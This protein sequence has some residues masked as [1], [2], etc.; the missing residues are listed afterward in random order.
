MK[1]DLV[2]GD[3]ETA[4]YPQI[5]KINQAFVHWL[6]PLDEK[7]L[8]ALLG[9]ATYARQIDAAAGVLIGYGHDVDY[10]HKNLHWLRARFEAFLY[11]DRI[12]IDGAAQGKGYGRVLY[13]DFE[14]EARKRGYPRLV[15]EVNVVPNNPGSHAFHIAQGFS[16][17]EDVYYPEYEVTLRYYVKELP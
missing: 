7:D 2:I 10:D 17:L 14:R 12:I 4:H 5:L 15:C 13:A 16:A 9:R 11:I 1:D 3:I 8:I 6:S